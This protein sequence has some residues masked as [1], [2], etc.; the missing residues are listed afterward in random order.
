[1]RKIASLESRVVR[2]GPFSRPF[3]ISLALGE[4]SYPADFDLGARL[5]AM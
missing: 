1:M 5:C 3:R 2:A 4:W